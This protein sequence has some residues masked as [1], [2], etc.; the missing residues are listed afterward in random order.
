[1]KQQR[2]TKTAILGLGLSSHCAAC[3]ASNPL[4]TAFCFK[5]GMPWGVFNSRIQEMSSTLSSNLSSQ[6]FATA[7]TP[8]HIKVLL[9]KAIS[10]S[11]SIQRYLVSPLPS[12]PALKSFI[13]SLI[14]F[15]CSASCLFFQEAYIL[16][17]KRIW[18]ST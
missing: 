17:R 12:L 3:S 8:P 7:R 18:A 4:F 15:A 16:P 5:G 9:I 14:L 13:S 6:L 10:Y 11:C 1:M 2:V